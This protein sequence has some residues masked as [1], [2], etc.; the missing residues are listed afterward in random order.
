MLWFDFWYLNESLDEF[1]ESSSVWGSVLGVS[2]HR[3]IPPEQQT[4]ERKKEEKNSDVKYDTS[5][6]RIYEV[7]FF[8]FK[9]YYLLHH[10]SPT[11]KGAYPILSSV[12]MEKAILYHLLFVYSYCL[13]LLSCIKKRYPIIHMIAPI[14]LIILYIIIFSLILF[15]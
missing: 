8:S 7:Y 1:Q 11:L 9:I 13:S 14:Y 5:W 12:V 3:V 10:N 15:S 4:K 2:P 6:S